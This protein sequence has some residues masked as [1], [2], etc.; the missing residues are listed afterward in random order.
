[1]TAGR[2]D[3]LCELLRNRYETTVV[4]GRFFEMPDHIRIGIGGDAA[5]LQAG[6]GCL[7]EALGALNSQ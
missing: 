5:E 2:V 3:D 1:M 4:P 6:L 7:A